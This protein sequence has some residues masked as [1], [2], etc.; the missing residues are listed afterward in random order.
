MG[1]YGFS[2]GR[3]RK[4]GRHYCRSLLYEIGGMRTADMT[5]KQTACRHI[6]YHFDHTVGLAHGYGLAVGSECSLTDFYVK[7][8]CGTLLLGKSDHST[9]RHGKDRR[10]DDIKSTLFA[11]H[12]FAL[13]G[14]RMCE[15]ATAVDISDGIN[16]DIFRCLAIPLHFHVIVHHNSSAVKHYAE[17]FESGRQ[18]RATAYGHEHGLGLKSLH[19]ALGLAYH[20]HTGFDCSH[21]CVGENVYASAF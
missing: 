13:C 2:Y 7:A 4:W 9:L 21:T 20:F 8:A 16:R 11:Q 18:Y 14:G 10:R 15:H 6:A 12:D 1:V 3:C 17:R 19:L 5:A